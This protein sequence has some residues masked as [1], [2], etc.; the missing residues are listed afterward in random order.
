MLI[1]SPWNGRADP[2]SSLQLTM[3]AE[4]AP[5]LPVPTAIELSEYAATFLTLTLT[6]TLTLNLLRPED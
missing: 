3:R 1:G 6:L 2:I 4:L 5:P